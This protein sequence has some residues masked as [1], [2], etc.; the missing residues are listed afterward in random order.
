MTGLGLCNA[1]SRSLLLGLL[2]GL[3]L[4]CCVISLACRFKLP[5]FGSRPVTILEASTSPKGNRRCSAP[6][7][8]GMEPLDLFKDEQQKCCRILLIKI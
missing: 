7:H 6:H 4:A 5:N 8:D 2:L 3:L 1:Q